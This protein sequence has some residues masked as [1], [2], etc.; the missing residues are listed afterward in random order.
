[1]LFIIQGKTVLS[2]DLGL[3]VDNGC[4]HKMHK[5]EFVNLQLYNSESI[6]YSI[7]AGIS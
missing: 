2:Y 3:V 1:M 4:V 5:R 6:V 7:L